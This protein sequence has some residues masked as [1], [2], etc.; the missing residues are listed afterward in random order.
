[1]T[2]DRITFCRY[3]K[4]AAGAHETRD[5]GNTLVVIEH[6][7]EMIKCADWI[8]DLG[9]SEKGGGRLL[10][11]DAEEIAEVAEALPDAI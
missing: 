2:H 10:G 11:R 3:R 4:A 5:A 1:M 6:N 9:R 8:M 7:L